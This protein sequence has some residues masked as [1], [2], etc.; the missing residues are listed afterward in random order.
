MSANAPINPIIP[1][2]APDPSLILV[3]ETYFLVNSTFH[4]FPG[5][6]IYTSRDLVHWH[7]I[8]NAINRPSQLSFSK[9]STLIHGIGNNDHLYATGGLYAPTLRH[10]NGTFYIVCTNVVNH[11]TDTGKESELQNFIISSTDIHANKWSDPVYFD[12]YGIDPSLF[13]DPHSGKA[14]LC[15]SK[16][17]GPST[18]ITLFEI[19]VQT[20]KKLSEEKQLWHGTGGIYPEGPHIYFRDG[21][22]YLMIAEGGTHEG[23]AV[24]MARSKNLL[25]GPWE[26]NP[27]NPILSAAGTDEYVQCTGHCEA[28]EAKDGTWWGVCLGIRMREQELY[29]LGRETFLTKGS[30]TPE[31]WLRFER[32]SMQLQIPNVP[33]D[34]MKKLTAAAGADYLYIHDPVLEDYKLGT[35]NAAVTLTSSPHDLTAANASPSFIGKRQRRF[36]GTSR[37]T[38]LPPT[39][40][41]TSVT[42]GLCVYKDEHRFFSVA[43]TSPSSISLRVRNTA[44]KIDRYHTVQ[45]PDNSQPLQFIVDYTELK[46]DVWY[47][48]GAVGQMIGVGSVDAMEISGKDFVGPIVG[49]FAVGE[50]KME[51]VFEGFDVDCE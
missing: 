37:A 40:N 15:G 27:L 47:R 45:L 26:P 3:D 12:F 30:W 2:F 13:F 14:Y 39:S 16:S 10:H 7:Q 19:D 20:G 18:K 50:G 34:P 28:F 8:G 25:D 1:G 11:G 4:L 23:H 51:V 5:L 35:A 32:A 42:A 44:K 49:V 9:A 46:Y 21:Y 36:H 48:L 43:Y 22:Y 29:G 38:L 33:V 31:G 41:N 17:P 24:T 6:P